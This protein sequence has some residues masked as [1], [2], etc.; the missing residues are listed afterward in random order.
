M[1][2]YAAGL[3]CKNCFH[4]VKHHDWVLHGYFLFNT[5]HAYYAMASG[6]AGLLVVVFMMEYTN[7]TENH[8]EDNDPL[9]SQ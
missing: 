2:Y 5:I 3:P 9:F 1:F 8:E 4:I 6:I 7:P